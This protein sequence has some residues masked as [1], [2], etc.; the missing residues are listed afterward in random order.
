MTIAVATILTRA[1]DLLQDTTVGGVRWLD[2][3][4]LRW[5]NDGQREIV[6]QR[7]DANAV[8]APS[9]LVPGTKQ[10]LPTGAIS[11][12]DVPRNMGIGGTTPGRSIR[13][14]QREVLD[15]QMPNWHTSAPSTEVKHFMFDERNPLNFYVY[16]PV[17]ASPAVQVELIYSASPTDC[18]LGGNFSLAD[19]YSNAIVDYIAYRA[20]SKDAEAASVQR[21]AGHYQ[22]FT[23]A[24]GIKKNEDSTFSPN[25]AA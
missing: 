8:N 19:I 14:I 10:V 18:G 4:L 16:P 13:L 9:Q 6:L 7:R 24:L 25:K 23:A 2:D 3:E 15:A 17:P 20:Y 12:I 11:L 5:L 21:A 22:V 1:R